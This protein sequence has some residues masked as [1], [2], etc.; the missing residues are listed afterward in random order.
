MTDV[1]KWVLTPQITAAGWTLFY[2][3]W[4]GAIIGVALG[5]IL[6]FTRAARKR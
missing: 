6:L 1:Q 2:S 3:L 5:A 4:Q